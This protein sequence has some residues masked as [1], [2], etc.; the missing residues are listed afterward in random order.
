MR[1][2]A[3]L[4]TAGVGVLAGFGLPILFAPYWWADV[5]GWDVGPHTDLTT[6]FA[7]CTGALVCVLA[8]AA[9]LAARRP[10]RNRWM[11]DIITAVAVLMVLVHL[12]GLGAEPASEVV[13]IGGYAGFAALTR[14]ARP[15]SAR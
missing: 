1:A 4:L 13:E 10:E 5:F 9:L 6:Y 15:A 12:R 2:R 3:F 14:W 11:F 7:R 8:V